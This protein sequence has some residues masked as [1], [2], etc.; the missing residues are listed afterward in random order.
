M[1]VSKS[2]MLEHSKA[3]V[4]LYTTYLA[5]YLNIISRD[6]Y[7][8]R[9]HLYDLFCGEGKYSDES[10]GS[11]LAALDKIRDHYFENNKSIPNMKILFN[12]ADNQ[13]IEKL[14]KLVTDYFKP[15][16]CH[17]ELRQMDYSS[18]KNEIIKEIEDYQDEKGLIFLD[19]YGYKEIKLDDIKDFLKGNKTEVILFLPISFMYRFAEVAQ[20]GNRPGYIPLKKFINEVFHPTIPSFKSAYDF[21]SKLNSEFRNK[22][23][24]YYVVTFTI[25]RDSKNVYCLFFFTSHIRGLEKMIEAKWK[26]DE[27]EGRGF[28]LSP[29][30]RL[31]RREE[32]TNFPRQIISFIKSKDIC[33]NEDLYKF[34]LFNEYLPK[35]MHK[36]LKQLKEEGVLF[37][38]P[39]TGEKIKKG[40]FYLPYNNHSS[41]PKKIVQFKIV[42]SK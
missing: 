27:N 39:L 14:A 38:A 19:P 26:I 23:E 22:L 6:R 13:K 21:A 20:K 5:I 28:E 34:G 42:V 17:I 41:Y 24:N 29:Q 3:K 40:A 1:T 16:N 10:I 25:E 15:H 18:L 31:F 30:S 9:I 8:K 7:T 36:F 11:P 12:D 32:L 2:Q 4:E 35:H 33:T 37:V